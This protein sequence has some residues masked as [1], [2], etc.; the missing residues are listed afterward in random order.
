M[1]GEREER[2]N[3]V[4][5]EL[6]D[7]LDSEIDLIRLKGGTQKEELEEGQEPGKHFFER[8][9]NSQE[10]SDKVNS[11][12]WQGRKKTKLLAELERKSLTSD[13]F[14]KVTKNIKTKM[15]L[16]DD[17]N[18]INENKDEIKKEDDDTKTLKTLS[19]V[20]SPLSSSMCG[21]NRHLEGKDLVSIN[22]VSTVST[23]GPSSPTLSSSSCSTNSSKTNSINYIKTVIPEE[24]ETKFSEEDTTVNHH[25]T[26]KDNE[27]LKNKKNEKDENEIVLSAVS[28]Y[29]EQKLE[30]AYKLL[31][32]KDAENQLLKLQIEKLVNQVNQNEKEEETP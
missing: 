27:T 11:N 13:F 31:C 30:N 23:N 26:G 20:S 9:Q 21:V 12:S 16:D 17:V 2:E 8:K 19:T 28:Q 4:Y 29:Y 3:A 25:R 5:D 15:G 22:S 24:K 14:C 1:G 32:E 6:Y 7:N 10:I 18:F